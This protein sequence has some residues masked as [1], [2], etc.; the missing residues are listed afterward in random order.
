MELLLTSYELGNNKQGGCIK[1]LQKIFRLSEKGTK[2][3]RVAVFATVLS[4]I[5]LLF[6]FKLLFDF[7]TEITNPIFNNIP[8]NI[9]RLWTLFF[10]GIGLAVIYL[11][12][13]LNEYD[14]TYTV[15][16]Q[17]SADTRIE[18][19]EKMRQ[20][21]LSFFNKKDLSE[22]TTNIMGDCATIEHSIS[23]VVPSLIANVIT[24]T[25]ACVYMGFYDWRMA[26]AIFG[27]MP[28]S[29]FIIFITKRLQTYLGAKHVE[30]KLEVSKQT[31]E[32]LE[33]IKVVKAFGLTGEKSKSLKKSMDEMRRIAMIFEAVAGVFVTLAQVIIRVG[34]GIVVL[35]GVR[36][37]LDGSLSMIN[38][39]YFMLISVRIYGPILTV[40]QLLPELFYLKTATER[41]QILRDE[42]IMDGEKNVDISNHKIKFNN[43]NFAYNEDDVIKNMSIEINEN[44][45]TAL[46]GPSGS[47]KST[48]SR[49]IA[50]F[51][52]VNGGNIT[53]GDKNIKQI[54]PERLMAE[55]SFVFQDVILFNDT[56]ANNIRLG[57]PDA[58]DDQVISIAKKARCHDFIMQLPDGYDS[59]LG[60]NGCTISGG[61]RQRISIARALLKD[62]P[63]IL[64]DEATASLDPQNEVL[65]QE[66]LSEL[67]KN[68]TVIVIAH[69][70]KTISSA[71]NIVVL[72]KGE[73]VEQGSSKQLL[74]QN[75]LYAKLYNIQQSSI[76]WS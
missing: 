59:L 72:D 70:L 4:N 40:L 37:L 2:N 11:F 75:G 51:W 41:V 61:E 24:I 23:H 30:A 67:M 34:T 42:P 46:V 68:K 47:G 33:G 73:I 76:G 66:A 63:I 19:A 3:L 43:V 32:Y 12:I 9:S 36:F 21:P 44:K 62:A 39:I 64:L 49:L 35:F 55:M 13:Y 22:L 18:L 65:I 5:A 53:I 17:E 58:T 69:R 31:Q 74:K 28:V 1:V 56:V 71:D 14:K 54:E 52:D 29:F 26:L 48:V 45:V 10:I 38:F 60:E 57:N 27:V 15:A 16:Y 50:R 7:I 6:P 20:L 8:L 25:F